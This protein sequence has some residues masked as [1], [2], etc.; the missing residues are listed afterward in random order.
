MFILTLR[1]SESAENTINRPSDPGRWSV[2][3]LKAKLERFRDFSVDLECNLHSVQKMEC[4]TSFFVL[5]TSFIV[6]RCGK[7]LLSGIGGIGGIATVN[8][9]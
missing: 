2:S 4:L 6:E 1:Y 7:Q 5:Q 3:C 8:I 9:L